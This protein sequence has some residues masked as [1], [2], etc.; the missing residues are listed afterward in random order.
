MEQE[1]QRR[2]AADPES[3]S[4]HVRDVHRDGPRGAGPDRGSVTR[5]TGEAEG[6]PPEPERLGTSGDPVA[7]RGHVDAGPEERGEHH[8]RSLPPEPNEPGPRVE[9]RA[10]DGPRLERGAGTVLENR[11]PRDEPD[12]TRDDRDHDEPARP[13][14]DRALPPSD[15]RVRA[16]AG[17]E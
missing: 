5:G 11:R 13:V 3:C 8:E 2:K 9:R 7:A 15:R 1:R 10:P 4:D 16:R 17:Q 12:E 6:E 14:D